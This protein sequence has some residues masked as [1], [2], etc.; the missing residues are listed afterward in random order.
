MIQALSCM[1]IKFSKKYWAQNDLTFSL[2]HLYG[3]IKLGPHN[4]KLDKERRKE[5]C[6]DLYSLY[7]FIST[8][9][10]KTGNSQAEHSCFKR[11]SWL[12]T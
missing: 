2:F 9:G 3:L 6:N 1:S 7:L 10:P 5:R 11:I 12:M 8:L 4:S